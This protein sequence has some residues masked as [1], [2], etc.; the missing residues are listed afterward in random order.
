MKDTGDSNGIAI[1]VA[2]M[3]QACDRLAHFT[4]ALRVTKCLAVAFVDD[5]TLHDEGVAKPLIQ[6]VLLLEAC[7][8]DKQRTVE[9]EYDELAHRRVGHQEREYEV[10]HNRQG[11]VR[12]PATGDRILRSPPEA[13][14]LEKRQEPRH[15]GVV[16]GNN[17]HHHQG[18][19]NDPHG[20]RLLET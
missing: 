8:V 4:D 11:N 9:K 18:Q 16:E 3:H 5:A 14:I 1:L 17:H 2:H 20:V 10:A 15:K 19:R 12:Q 13:H 6:S 7:P